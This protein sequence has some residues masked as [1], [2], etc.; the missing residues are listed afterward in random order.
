[1]V[2]GT[3]EGISEGVIEGVLEGI[4]VDAWEGVIELSMSQFSSDFEGV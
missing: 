2:E 1:M 3:L 4:L